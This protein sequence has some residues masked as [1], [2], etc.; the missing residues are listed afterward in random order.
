MNSHTLINAV[1]RFLAVQ[2]T[3]MVIVN[4]LLKFLASGSY[5]IIYIY[6]NETFPTRGRNT[7][8]GVCSMI[9][10]LGA[11][12]GTFSNDH[13][14]RPC[15]QFVLFVEFEFGLDTRVATFA[16]CGL[17]NHLGLCHAAGDSLSRNGGSTTTADGSRRRTHGTRLVSSTNTSFFHERSDHRLDVP[18]RSIDPRRNDVLM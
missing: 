4:I 10:R 17:W 12:I 11:I 1:D 18:V 15:N 2:Y 8:M 3:L 7:G 5:G 13:L 9:A 6:A 16:H 14:V